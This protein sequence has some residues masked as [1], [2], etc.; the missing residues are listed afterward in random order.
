MA[1]L[2]AHPS[3]E[4]S[5]LGKILGRLDDHG[6]VLYESPASLVITPDTL[7]LGI[8]GRS[9]EDTPEHL[10]RGVDPVLLVDQRR[11]VAF[12]ARDEEYNEDALASLSEGWSTSVSLRALLRHSA[13]DIDRWWAWGNLR[14]QAGLYAGPPL[15]HR[16]SSSSA[17]FFTLV[18]AL[19]DA[20]GRSHE[21]DVGLA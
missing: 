10:Q 18:S 21:V 14:R 5:E 9:S 20:D 2:A 15:R 3:A 11:S 13:I 17:R 4:P 8:G 7:R 16:S 19:V 6:L 12:D 1:R